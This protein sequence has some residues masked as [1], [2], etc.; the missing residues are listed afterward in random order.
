M[1][2]TAGAVMAMGNDVQGEKLNK[3]HDQAAGQVDN[4]VVGDPVRVD[5]FELVRALGRLAALFDAQGDPG[6]KVPVKAR[7]NRFLPEGAQQEETGQTGGK[8]HRGLEHRIIAP[9]VGQN[10]SDDIGGVGVRRAM[11]DVVGGE[12]GAGRRR[13]ITPVGKIGKAVKKQSPHHQDRDQG[14]GSQ[15]LVLREV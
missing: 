12:M 15:S 14:K 7:F 13:R 9:V 10:G 11:L 2:A 5:R 8:D 4:H 3:G 6:G 1:K